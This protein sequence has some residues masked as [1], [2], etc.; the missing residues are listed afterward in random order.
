MR[1]P[2][3]VSGVLDRWGIRNQST[4]AAVGVVA[5]ALLAGGVL[6]LVLLQNALT[7]S[8]DSVLRTKANDVAALITSQDVAEAGQSISTAARVDLLIQIVDASGKV[9]EASDPSLKTRPMSSLDS[10]PGKSEVQTVS[11]L[12]GVPGDGEYYVVATG[13]RSGS[14]KY[15]VLTARSVQVQ[16]DTV[17]TVALFLLLATPVLLLIVGLSVRF[18]VGR[19]L[20]QVETIR[21]QV[22][23]IDG[24]RLGDRVDVPPTRDE[25]AA[26]AT[27][28]N[29]MLSRIET[30]DTAQRQFLSHAS[31]ELRSPLTTLR[32]GLEVSAGDPT[33][34]AWQDIAPV[35]QS[36]TLRMGHLVED[37]LTLSKADDSGFTLRRTDVD[38]DDVLATELSR[39]RATGSRAVVS[40]VQPVRVAGDPGRL[41]QILRNVLDNAERHALTTVRATLK[42]DKGEAVLWID[43][44]GPPVPAPERE[45]I[46]ERFVRLDESR[47]RDTGGSGLGLAIARTLAEAHGG[48]ITTGQAPD[49]FC[50]FE[51]RLPLLD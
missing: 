27:T 51:I 34:R 5:L 36:E 25:L 7:A 10:A 14:E 48:T 16:S 19:S 11:T 18:L 6:L 4:A 42:P 13:A 23:V 44:D 22:A 45:R 49:G 37:L 1:L 33:H 39:L 15:V 20:R 50:R 17:R 32:T 35:L 46:F 43:N 38:L 40:Q 30:A 29:A 9:V 21:S 8:T 28:M 24:R 41:A 31:H 47:S 12:A 2:R 3:T 26:L